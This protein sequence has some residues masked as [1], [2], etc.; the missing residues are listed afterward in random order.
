MSKEIPVGAIVELT[1]SKED[2]R[3]VAYWD[4]EMPK[5]CRQYMIMSC[6]TG[7][8][9]RVFK[10]QLFEKDTSTYRDINEFFRDQLSQEIKDD[11]LNSSMSEQ[12]LSLQ[13]L[14]DTSPENPVRSPENPV[15]SPEN[16]V[17]ST[18]NPVRSPENSVGSPENTVGSPENPIGS[19]VN[20]VRTPETPTGSPRSP[21]D[22]HASH[23]LP[24]KRFKVITDE[25]IE[26]LASRTT[27]R[28]TNSMTKWAIKLFKG[29]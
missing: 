12:E 11:F 22:S 15:T 4:N 21:L 1:G 20:P 29:A 28:T 2:W 13:D 3:V 24:P 17:R 8:T 25:D 9:K 18:Q 27:E 26:T 16:P 14:L 19:P 7:V 5:F 6:H 23:Q 10:H